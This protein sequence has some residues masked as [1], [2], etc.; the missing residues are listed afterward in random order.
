MHLLI[1]ISI[2]SIH[3]LSPCFLE[4][5]AFSVAR[6]SRWVRRA[7]PRGRRYFL[8]ANRTGLGIF[9]SLTRLFDISRFLVM[10][11]VL[12]GNF[13]GENRCPGQPSIL[14]A[15]FTPVQD[16]T[17]LCIRSTIVGIVLQ[18]LND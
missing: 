3:L 6:L 16:Y 10:R 17:L 5:G 15:L 7:L 9:D 11:Y 12:F 2:S 18:Y 8:D 1:C 14:V 13:F 4:F